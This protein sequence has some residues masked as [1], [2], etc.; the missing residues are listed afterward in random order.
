MFY[1]QIIVNSLGRE[2]NNLYNIIANCHFTL[3]F[4]LRLL[5]LLFHLPVIVNPLGGEFIQY[6]HLLFNNN[7]LYVLSMHGSVTLFAIVPLAGEYNEVYYIYTLQY[8]QCFFI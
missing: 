8:L 4:Y 2:F 7:L 5:F 3:V 1:F 6:Y